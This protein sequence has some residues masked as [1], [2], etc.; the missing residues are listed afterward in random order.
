MNQPAE[1]SAWRRIPTRT[2]VG[3]TDAER[4]WLNESDG[5]LIAEWQHE[6]ADGY[7]LY[8]CRHRRTGGKPF[9]FERYLKDDE[10]ASILGDQIKRVD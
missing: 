9:N 1:G 7:Y 4:L 2:Y 10:A 6:R 8:R 5:Y 3:F